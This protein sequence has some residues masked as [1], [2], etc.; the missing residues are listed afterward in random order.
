MWPDIDHA[1]SLSLSYSSSS[2]S[3]SLQKYGKKVINYLRSIKPLAWL[4]IVGDAFHNFADGLAL[5]ASISQSLTLGIST[6]IAL[7]FHEIPHEL[8]DFFI[9]LSTGMSWYAALFF[10]FVSAL[11]AIL[12][13]FVGVAIGTASETATSWILA[14]A[15]GIFIYIALVDMVSA[16]VKKT[17]EILSLSLQF[18]ELIR[19]K[20][21]SYKRFVLFVMMNIGFIIS[22]IALLLLA[23]YEEDL[24]TLFV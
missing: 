14:L 10:N 5:G 19:I 17:T 16:L 15:A 23:I 2:S 7:I 6:T 1:H 22:Y 13:L 11:T 4:I 8:G 12:G 18:P 24:N 9:L 3:S 21:K 20:E